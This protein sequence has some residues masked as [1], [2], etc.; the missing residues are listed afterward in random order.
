MAKDNRTLGQFN[1]SGIAPAPRGL[2]QIEVE[3]NI[4]ANGILHVS[5]TDKG[6][7]KSQKI[8]ITGSAGLSDEEIER[9]KKDAEAHA[10]EDTKRREFTEARN[11]ADAMVYQTRKALEEHGGKVSAEVRSNI[12]QALS[13]VEE[14]LKG[15]D[16]D[17]L[18][19]ALENLEKTSMELGKAVYEAQ[20]QQQATPDSAPGNAPGNV[21]GGDPGAAPGG[22][23]GS[24]SK[25]TES[26]EKK[27][28]DSDV[29]DA[30][31]EVK[32]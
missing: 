30:D 20:A 27:K 29:I 21:P 22:D 2:P 11:K 4:D 16:T 14:A 7:G 25:E 6:T 12:E 31:F 26:S 18:N 10:A 23:P 15:E 17:T 13:R 32:E 9:M 5:A 24:E 1:L 8:E 3:F 19:N 28:D